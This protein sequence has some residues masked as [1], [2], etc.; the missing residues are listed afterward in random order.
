MLPPIMNQVNQSIV[1][2]HFQ[3]EYAYEVVKKYHCRGEI[4]SRATIV[5]IN[6]QVKAKVKAT[7]IVYALSWTKWGRS[8]VSLGL[9]IICSGVCEF[10]AIYYLFQ[11][12][13]L[14]MTGPISWG[15]SREQHGF[16]RVAQD[17][18]KPWREKRGHPEADETGNSWRIMHAR[19]RGMHLWIG[20][21]DG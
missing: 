16:L 9:L 4:R 18:K 10:L 20:E 17:Q 13:K 19:Q 14:I 1:K 12:L 7:Y 11:I 15:R 5:D 21:S 6:V 2:C 3:Q 8:T